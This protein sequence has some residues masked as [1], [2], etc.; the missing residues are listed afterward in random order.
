[1]KLRTKYQI[2]SG[3]VTTTVLS[4]KICE[5]ENKIPNHDRYITTL[6]F[7]KLIAENFTAR[8]KQANLVTKTDFL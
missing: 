7:N 6:E 8:L 4:T 2:P 5:V 1:M 3:S